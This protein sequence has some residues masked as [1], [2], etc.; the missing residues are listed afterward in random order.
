[1]T[2]T[3]TETP[4]KTQC[5][6]KGRR[7]WYLSSV[8][9]L[10]ASLL[11]NVVMYFAYEDYFRNTATPVERF[12]SGA[13]DAD[14]LIAV[15]PL[16]GTIMGSVTRNLLA[17]IERAREDDR[18]RGVLLTIDSPGGLVADSHQIYH[19]LTELRAK[20]P[21]YVAMKRI[22]ASGGVYVAMGAGPEGKIF[23]EPTTWT[24]SIGVIIPRYNLRELSETYGVRF[25]P[26]TTGPLK[27]TLSPFRDLT[28]EEE[29]VWEVIIQDSF[30]RFIGVIA[31]NRTALERRDVEQLATGQIYT[32]QQALD[33]HLADATAYEDEA[34]D[35]LQKDLGL[36][37]AR[38]VT[39]DFP[40]DLLTTLTGF[41]ESRDPEA[42]WETVL[43][44][45]TPQAMYYF[46][47]AP[48]VNAS[49]R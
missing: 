11:A 41:I 3:P 1:M 17:Q 45:S 14:D 37:E 10:S 21:V 15:L 18:V 5:T 33:H 9:V 13:K 8:C 7:W 38:V 36:E 12:H 31:D 35:I 29:Q 27:D 16:K 28:Q 30:Q 42:P 23:V 4:S 32:A 2:D 20:K 26:L 19:A 48:P 25:E 24:G 46:G 40:V 43:D 49:S 22:A 47:W 44:S 6:S 39:Y 34:I